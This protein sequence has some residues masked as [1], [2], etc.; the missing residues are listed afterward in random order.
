MVPYE[1]G[2]VIQVEAHGKVK[3]LLVLDVVVDEG[4]YDLSLLPDPEN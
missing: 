4:S 2:E 3:R 1:K